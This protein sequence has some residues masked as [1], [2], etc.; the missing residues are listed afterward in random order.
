MRSF[1]EI[2]AIAADRKGGKAALEKLLPEPT[3]AAELAHLPEDRWLAQFTKSV[4][5]AGFNWKVIEAKWDGFE[6]AFDGFDVGKCAMM[7]DEKLDALLKDSRIVRNGAKIL[8]VRDNAVF[9]MEL[10]D[11]GGAGKVL[12][13]W[14]AT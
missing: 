9:L 8:T 3:P 7:D 10:R 5:Q 1:D 12:G 11:G 13:G 14:P 2:Y 4:F 6:D